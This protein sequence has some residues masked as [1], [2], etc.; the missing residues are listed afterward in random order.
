MDLIDEFIK[1]V[2]AGLFIVP[3]DFRETVMSK[4]NEGFEKFPEVTEQDKEALYNQ[5]LAFYSK[6]HYIPEFEIEKS[7]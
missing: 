3:E 4:I 6:Y 7:Q 5:I 2:P 1:D